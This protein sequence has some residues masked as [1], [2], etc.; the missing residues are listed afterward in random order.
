MYK[1]FTLTLV[2]LF[3]VS[4]AFAATVTVG[5]K[6]DVR[7]YM[8]TN[9]DQDK[10]TKTTG[11][12]ALSDYRTHGDFWVTSQ[13]NDKLSGKLHFRLHDGTNSKEF[14][15]SVDTSTPPN[16]DFNMFAATHEAYFK[17]MPI[18]NLNITL[19]RQAWK[20]GSGFFVGD[21]DG[22]KDPYSQNGLLLT[23][24]MPEMFKA[25]LMYSILEDDTRAGTYIEEKA[26]ANDKFYGLWLNTGMVPFLQNVN[27]GYLTKYMSDEAATDKDDIDN[28]LSALVLEAH[29]KT[30]VGP[31]VLFYGLLYGMNMGENKAAEVKYSGMT[32]TPY[33]GFAMPDLAG[34]SLKLQYTVFTGDKGDDADKDKTWQSVHDGATIFFDHAQVFGN[35]RGMATAGLNLIKAE[36]SAYATKT[37]KG[38]FYYGMYTFNEKDA[39]GMSKDGLSD[40][41]E[42]VVDYTGIENLSLQLAVASEKRNK[43]NYPDAATAGVGKDGSYYTKLAAAYTF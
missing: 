31:S 42:L 3:S 26:V 35:Y 16:R 19:G 33:L 29:G 38:T 28:T 24:E 13:V 10:D 41:M 39:L 14:W 9:A 25:S 43:D 23:Y 11:T 6:I 32:Y 18:E 22:S 36:L 20:M 40:R 7:H 21:V 12:E 37:L 4:A 30:P 34:L 15:G 27:L 8:T 5:G 2:L 17:Y 1:I